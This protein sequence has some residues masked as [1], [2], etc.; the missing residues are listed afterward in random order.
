MKIEK[1][2]ANKNIKGI[3]KRNKKIEKILNRSYRDI[4]KRF[5]T[6]RGRKFAKVLQTEIKGL[7][8]QLQKTMEQGIKTHWKLASEMSNK[9]TDGYLQNVNVSNQL[10]KTFR[11]PNLDALNTF[12]NRAES[13]SK[14]SDRVWN[15]TENLK[16]QMNELLGSGITSGKS[17]VQVSKDMER[18]MNGKG[19]QYSGT[20]I[21]AA[22][23][24]FQA[25]RL[26][27]TEI[28]MAYRMSEQLKVAKLPFIG[29]C[30]IHLSGG[31]PRIDICDEL[32]GDYPKGF[33]WGGWHPLCIC[34]RTWKTI[35]KKAFVKLMRTGK[36]AK[37]YFVTKMPSKMHSFIE[38]YGDRIKKYKTEPYWVRDNFTEDLII[39]KDVVKRSTT[40]FI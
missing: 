26:A 14:L 30:T 19:I 33:M 4:A 25:V 18:F 5:T 7:R 1:E 15:L 21:K 40:H 32:Y 17:A 12:I 16:K 10:Y 38:K 36:V 28:N 11:S 35:P 37:K 31:H 34:Y 22:N 23:I 3:I 13:G 9:I 29:G 39:S 20:L 24:T 6:T 27:S 8:A 2:Y